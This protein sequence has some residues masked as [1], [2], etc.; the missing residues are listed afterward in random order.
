MGKT[1]K[2]MVNVLEDNKEEL[3]VKALLF[4]KELLGMVV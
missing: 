3:L 1:T 2:V 4:V